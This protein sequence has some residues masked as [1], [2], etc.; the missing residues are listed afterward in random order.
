MKRFTVV[1]GSYWGT[2][3]DVAGRWYIVDRDGDI[4]DKRGRG[5]SY[6]DARAGAKELNAHIKEVG[7]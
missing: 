6:R 3:D 5:Q 4:I 1:E 2:S 7:R